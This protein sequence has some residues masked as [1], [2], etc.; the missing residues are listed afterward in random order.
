MAACHHLAAPGQQFRCYDQ[1]K[2]TQLILA[3]RDGEAEPNAVLSS[4]ETNV[5]APSLPSLKTV[6]KQTCLLEARCDS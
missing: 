1:N 2:Q 6:V 5:C 4:S 3:A